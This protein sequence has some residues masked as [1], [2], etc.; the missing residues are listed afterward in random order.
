MAKLQAEAR[1][2]AAKGEAE[3]QLLIAQAEANAIK[4]KSVEI[5]RALGFEILETLVF[6]TDENGDPVQT[7][8]EYTINFEGKSEAQIAMITDYL[9][10]VAYLEAW[11]GELPD[12]VV[13]GEN[14]SFILPLPG[15]EESA[16]EA[17]KA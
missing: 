10:Y 1:I 13:T 5:A 7:A 3:A 8:V 11:N 17:D 9:K 6:E 15:G 14:G 16:P 2:A 4:A 12:T